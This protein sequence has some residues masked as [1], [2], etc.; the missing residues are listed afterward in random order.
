[1]PIDLKMQVIDKIHHGTFQHPALNKFSRSN[2]AL[3]CI[4]MKLKVSIFS[5]GEAIYKQGD[6]IS[7]FYMTLKGA[8]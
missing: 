2:R 1:M 5:A 8:A 7:K 6:D 4:G 3:A